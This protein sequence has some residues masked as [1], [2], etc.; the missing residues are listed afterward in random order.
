M[1]VVKT[2]ALPVPQYESTFY[3]LKTQGYVYVTINQMPDVTRKTNSK[4]N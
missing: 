2:T 3:C 4:V 1:E